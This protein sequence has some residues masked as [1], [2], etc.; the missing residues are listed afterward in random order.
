MKLYELSSVYG[1]RKQP[2]RK[3]R[4]QGTGNGK[5]AGRGHKGQKARA[6]G[7]V[8]TG[9][10][11]GQMPLYRRVPKRGFNNKIFA[12]VYAHVNV[13]DLNRFKDGE[14]VSYTQLREK[15]LV[16]KI[17]DGVVV[18]G[19]GELNKKL[20]VEAARFS[21]TAAQKIEAAGGKVEVI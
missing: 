11:G 16:N 4:G 20:T 14:V 9:F 3:G 5:T 12:K 7:G 2:K 10:E 6:G 1:A 18:L 8:R 19:N 13:E 21:K 17:Y 15:G